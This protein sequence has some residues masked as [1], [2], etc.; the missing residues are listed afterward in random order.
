VQRSIGV[1]LLRNQAIV[2]VGGF[3]LPLGAARP[4]ACCL[5]I[6]MQSIEDIGMS[7]GLLLSSHDC[8][9]YRRRLDHEKQLR[10]D[11]RIYVST[12]ESNTARFLVVQIWSW[13]RIT[14]DLA[15]RSFVEHP[16][17]TRTAPATQQSGEQSAATP[18]SS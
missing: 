17:H 10:G 16:Q 7:F 18:R 1:Q 9:L 3:K 2:W 6:A 13:A 12:A 14:N 5:E 4:I 8:C 11:G 15:I